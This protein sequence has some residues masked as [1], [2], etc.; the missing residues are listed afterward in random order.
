MLYKFVFL[1][2]LTITAEYTLA[3]HRFQPVQPMTCMRSMLACGHVRKNDPTIHV[4]SQK[5]SLC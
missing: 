4:S 2:V 5:K 1:A 3:S